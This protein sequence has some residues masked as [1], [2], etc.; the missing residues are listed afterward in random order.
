[1]S[2]V[3]K[4][5]PTEINIRNGERT[6]YGECLEL[7]SYL[8][9][10]EYNPPKD[11]AC[12]LIS[13]W[14]KFE[15]SL[16]QQ[17]EEKHFVYSCY[18]SSLHF[19]FNTNP[20]SLLN[21]VVFSILKHDPESG[22]CVETYTYD[23]PNDFFNNW[24][25]FT[26]YVYDSFS[27]SSPI[28][29]LYCDLQALNVAFVP[30]AGTHLN[31]YGFF[32]FFTRTERVF[33]APG[34]S[35]LEEGCKPCLSVLDLVVCGGDAGDMGSVNYIPGDPDPPIYYQ[36]FEELY[37]E[38]VPGEINDAP[39]L[40]EGT[41]IQVL[42]YKSFRYNN[43]NQVR[44]G[45]MFDLYNEL[46]NSIVGKQ[47]FDPTANYSARNFS[48]TVLRKSIRS[49]KELYLERT[50]NKNRFIGYSF[51]E[52]NHQL[53]WIKRSVSVSLYPDADEVE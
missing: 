39:S 37:N 20:L 17:E 14:S 30:F 31:Y 33:T 34:F 19:Y 50:R 52:F 1:M 6:D 38:G 41:S 2:N 15:S 45:K 43:G 24:H 49:T 35:F 40:F 48:R 44:P 25:F 5:S 51:P 29:T 10:D 12:H 18:G 3:L 27:S 23:L 8:L 16:L 47:F 36:Y 26:L 4:F 28:P 21:Q 42:F 22:N 7:K 9:F 11:I 32:D 53:S 13:F 46:D